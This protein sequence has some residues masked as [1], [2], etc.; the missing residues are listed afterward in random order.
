M[1]RVILIQDGDLNQLVFLS[2]NSE[3]EKKKKK[4]EKKRNER[5][6]DKFQNLCLKRM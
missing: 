3:F 5:N 2:L 4:K 6:R 1:Y